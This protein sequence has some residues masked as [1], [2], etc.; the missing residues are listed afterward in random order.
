MHGDAN[1]QLE[2]ALFALLGESYPALWSS[3]EIA[4]ELAD[5]P[6][7]FAD[8]DA[9]SIAIRALV[10]RGLIR[11]VASSYQATRAAVHAQRL[12]D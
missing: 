7:R 1:D 3:E 10:R 4:L 8:R 2:R 6:D 11:A 5:D 12:T 9:I